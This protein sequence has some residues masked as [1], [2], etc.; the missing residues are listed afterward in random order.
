MGVIEH[1]GADDGCDLT[2]VFN[3]ISLAASGAR[4][5]K[6]AMWQQRP[7]RTLLQSTRQ[8]TREA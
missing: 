6:G 4:D 7:V 1:L 3:S 5:L 8:E 2:D